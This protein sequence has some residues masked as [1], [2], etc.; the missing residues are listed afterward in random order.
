MKFERTERFK[1]QYKKLTEPHRALL[2]RALKLF[3]T[4]PYHPSLHTKR[5]QGTKDIR[6]ARASAALRFTFH[7][8]EDRIILRTCGLHDTVLHKP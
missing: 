5:V 7:W 8:R 6:E 3:A 1:R 2:Y 4:D